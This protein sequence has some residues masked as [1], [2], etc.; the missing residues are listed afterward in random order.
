M[1]FDIA[2]KEV[3]HLE[4]IGNIFCMLSKVI[5]G[6]MA[7]GVEKAAD[8]PDEIT[9]GTKAKPLRSCTAR[10]AAAAGEVAQ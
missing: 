6:K 3:S 10:L 9:Q 8:L 1:L 7:E 4:I 2:I 5:K